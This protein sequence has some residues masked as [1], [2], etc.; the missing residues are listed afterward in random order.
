MSSDLILLVPLFAILLLVR[1][2]WR[3]WRRKPD[4][5]ERILI[6]GSNVLFWDK[7][8]PKIE[9]VVGLVWHLRDRGFRPG[10][11]FDATVGYKLVNRYQDDAAM[12]A[13]LSLPLEDVLV[14]PKGTSADD[15]LLK[16]A[17]DIG[18]KI[19]TNDRYR[20]WAEAYPEVKEPGYLVKGGVTKGEVWLEG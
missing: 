5:R 18:A 14:V 13:L 1:L 20:D 11:I 4:L 2:I 15:Y 16:A 19:V 9:T 3:A 7:N 6:D 12:A 8:E 10:V 17:R